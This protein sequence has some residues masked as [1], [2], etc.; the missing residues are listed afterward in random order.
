[1]LHVKL[2]GTAVCAASMFAS[3]TSSMYTKSREI[4]PLPLIIGR[5]PSRLPLGTAG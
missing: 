2:E 5:R 3:T 1:M 4:S